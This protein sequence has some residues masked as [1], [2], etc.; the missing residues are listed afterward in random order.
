[1]RHRTQRLVRRHV[2]DNMTYTG[3]TCTRWSSLSALPSSSRTTSRATSLAT[4]HDVRD[5][6][7][8]LEHTP[9]G[10]TPRGDRA[11][12]PSATTRIRSS[13]R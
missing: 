1:M 8:G 6:R 7:I 3:S 2:V 13:R 10:I 9:P 12:C 11:P 5:V 4:S